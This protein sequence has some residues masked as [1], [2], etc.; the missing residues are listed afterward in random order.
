[1]S[2]EY[3]YEW[4]SGAEIDDA[5][6]AE[7]SRL[8]T[9]HYGTW[10]PGAHKP[11]RPISLT[12]KLLRPFLPEEDGWA[13]LARFR[14]E[15]V[16][17]A[18]G[19]RARVSGGEVVDWVT[20]LVT[21][22][23]HRRLGVAKNMLLTFWGFSN[24]LAWGLVTSNPYTVRA[25]ERI[26]HR[27]C[28]PAT[29]AK[30]L[31]LI[32]DIGARIGYVRGAEVSVDESRSVIDTKFHIDLA[33]LPNKLKSA[34]ERAPWVLGQICEGEEWLA[35]T[36]RDQATMALEPAEL[37]R[38]L[39]QSDR[40]V[41]KAY[42]RMDLGP[43]HAWMKHTVPEVDFAA[44]TLG[45]GEGSRVLDIGCGKGRHSLA[46]ARRGC[47]VV[48]VDFV[49]KFIEEARRDAEASGVAGTHFVHGDAREE[50]LGEGSF[51]AAICL[52]DAVGT[53]ADQRRNQQLVDSIRRH[54]K[55]GGRALV[56]VLNMEVTKLLG[57]RRGSVE[58]DPGLLL[59]L[60]A[61]KVMQ[62]SG[63]IFD[64][65]YFMLDEETGIVYRREQFEGDGEPPGEYIVRDRR[66]TQ[67]DIHAMCAHA[68][69]TL[70][71]TRPV[72]LGKWD[73][74]LDSAT[75]ERAKELLFLVE[76]PR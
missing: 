3:E 61:S 33:T 76:R 64:P 15:L 41:R 65:K 75:D 63:Q 25:L 1:M 14:G 12:P 19:V 17:H 69:F 58:D 31:D 49:E 6:L 34:S 73:K 7:C 2:S 43:M 59:D 26:T 66:Y 39:D 40:T 11:G 46:L 37:Q 10:G 72:A 22:K 16:G 8:F 5:L 4:R 53:Y 47:E 56:S 74:S 32:R 50:N 62:N 70:L 13:I 54:L 51:D 42:A 23:Q 9:E 28:E 48:G 29:I 18:F 36:F 20:Q 30:H 35:F 21:H 45:L 60:P 68:G 27:R 24:H 38:M 71:W 55:P 57:G 67:E 44:A 52:Y